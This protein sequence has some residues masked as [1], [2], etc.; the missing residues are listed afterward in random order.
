MGRPFKVDRRQAVKAW[1]HGQVAK[2]RASGVEMLRARI[3]ALEAEVVQTEREVVGAFAEA[4][5]AEAAER[6]KWERVLE[7]IETG[8]ARE[9]AA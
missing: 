7:A 8:E 4:D 5:R 6:A 3:V 9:V 1:I 2:R